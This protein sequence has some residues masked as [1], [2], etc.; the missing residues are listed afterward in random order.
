MAVKPNLNKQ[1]RDRQV[2]GTAERLQFAAEADE[3]VLQQAARQL[4]Q[5]HRQQ[6]LSSLQAAQ[7]A[8]AGQAEAAAQPGPADAA[9]AAAAGQAETAAQPGL[10][11]MSRRCFHPVDLLSGEKVDLLDDPNPCFLG[12]SLCF[13]SCWFSRRCPT[14][15]SCLSC[16]TPSGWPTCCPLRCA[17]VWSGWSLRVTGRRAPEVIPYTRA[18][19]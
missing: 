6:L 11:A 3:E 2:L 5:P 16:S 19:P 18:V 1:T 15:R 13:R 14:V 12:T 17:T 8:A 4:P 10:S 7:A 9:Q